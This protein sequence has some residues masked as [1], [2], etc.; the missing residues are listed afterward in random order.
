M[1]LIIDTTGRRVPAGRVTQTLT[2]PFLTP[3]C[4]RG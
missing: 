3:R 2:E 4:R 1:T